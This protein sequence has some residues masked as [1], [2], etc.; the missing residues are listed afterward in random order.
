MRIR[1]GLRVVAIF[2]M[3]AVAGPAACQRGDT[4]SA[5]A[6][7]RN[8]CRLA[9]QVLLE[10]HPAN[11]RAWAS[12]YILTCPEEAPEPLARRWRV[13]TEDPIQHL[14]DFS[15]RI[16]DRRIFDAVYAVAETESRPEH[17]RVAALALLA[18]YADPQLE[19]HVDELRP[20]ADGRVRP[21]L[22]RVTGGG[23]MRVVQPLGGVT[24]SVIRLLE[25]IADDG[26]SP[27]TVRHAAS[28]L[29][30]SVRTDRP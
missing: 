20:S 12:E 21:I 16:P 13:T 18:R 24:L 17:V 30:R 28:V 27:R 9:R 14:V 8:Q 6:R 19:F 2:S 26:T 23:Q 1:P 25:R 10:G 29:A 3:L 15:F 11:R 7:H 5:M 4:T 22:A